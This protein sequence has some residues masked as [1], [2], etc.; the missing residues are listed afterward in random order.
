M[1]GNHDHWSGANE[2]QHALERG[3]VEVLRNQH[4]TITLRH[5]RLQ[6]VGLDDAYTGHARRDEAVKGL[7]RDL[8]S[9]G[10]SHIA[11]EADG[12]W[13]HGVPLVLSGHTHGGQVTV[14]RL[15][16]LAVGMI[17]GHKYVHGLYGSRRRHA[18]GAHSDEA[19]GAV[20][21]GAGIGAAVVPLRI[22]DR[23]RR[24][25]TIFELG[26]EPGDFVE[27]HSEQ[28]PMRG[29]KPTQEANCEARGGRDPQAHVT[30]AQPPGLAGVAQSPARRRSRDLRRKS[31]INRSR[32]GPAADAA[33]AVPE[34]QSDAAD[35]R[36]VD[37]CRRQ[38]HRAVLSAETKPIPLKERLMDRRFSTILVLAVAALF[39]EACSSSGGGGTGGTGGG[40]PSTG[41][42]TGTGGAGMGGHATGGV[43]GA[44]GAATGGVTGA[45]G[46]V[47]GGADTAT[48]SG[49]TTGG[50]DASD[51]PKDMSVSDTTDSSIVDALDPAGPEKALCATQAYMSTSAPPFTAVEF[52]T[53]YREIC[54]TT[55]GAT[56][57][58]T[59]AACETAY[60][61]YN[62]NPDAGGGS[63]GPNGQKGC[64]T[65]HLCN[66][67]QI[68]LTI[69]CPHAT[70]FANADAGPGGPCP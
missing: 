19:K 24:E 33:R 25:V 58:A 51:A 49:G 18:P 1:L 47:D 60:T 67:N 30:R 61:G 38:T 40:S 45:G 3:G 50:T 42:T 59:E 13:R 46:K 27:H 54:N 70:G 15:H 23:G 7:R 22:G 52:C 14:A 53:L 10:L 68:S 17:A 6:V 20:Y 12:L 36:R 69:H 35:R 43:T 9:I 26:C 11:E 28:E 48:S 55:V 16:E 4:T 65:Y 32:S 37:F 56:F 57:F 44:G 62:T 66:A 39:A 5:E 63:E 34:F 2:V 21:V 31:V 8:P 64:R 29:R 41:G